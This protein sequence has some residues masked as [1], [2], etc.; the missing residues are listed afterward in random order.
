MSFIQLS[1]NERADLYDA[2][3][4][5]HGSGIQEYRHTRLRGLSGIRVCH[6]KLH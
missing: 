5:M 6:E 4:C 1:T 3:I 2:E